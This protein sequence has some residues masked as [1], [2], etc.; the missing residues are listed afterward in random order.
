MKNMLLLTA[1]FAIFAVASVEAAPANRIAK[2][3]TVT[4]QI[5]HQPGAPIRSGDECWVYTDSRGSGFWDGCDPQ[6]LTPRGI[7]LRGRSEADIAAIENASGGDG[8]GGGGSR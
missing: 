1:A 5:G 2:K 6:A 7:S 8:G 3:P 4:K